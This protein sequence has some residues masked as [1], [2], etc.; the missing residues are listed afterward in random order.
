M[1]TS[2]WQ[3]DLAALDFETTGL[4][5]ER[6][7]R[8]IEVAVVRGRQGSVPQ[9]WSA[10]LDPGRPVDATEIHGITDEMV[11]G[12]P[13]FAERAPTLSRMLRGAVLVAHNAPF[14]LNF[15]EMEYGRAGLWAPEVPVLDT[16]G[17]SRRVLALP[18]HRL[19]SI[20]EHLGID[21][22]QAHRAL[23]DAQATWDMAWQLL[24]RADPERRL[25]IADAERLC[26]RPNHEELRVVTNALLDA[27]RR[28]QPIT[29]DYRRAD[30]QAT[31]R[32]I[33]VRKVIGSRVEAFCH[34]RGEDRVFRMDRISLV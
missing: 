18:S 2:L 28:A 33:T 7:D 27:A 17:L 29:I 1:S 3:V 5:T 13:T 10:L 21:R 20:C 16:L 24:D 31:R 4:S 25:T 19:A 26:R 12:Q 8:A 14:D 15:L 22:G 34:L 9:R 32:S 23:D 6:G 11:R 30:A